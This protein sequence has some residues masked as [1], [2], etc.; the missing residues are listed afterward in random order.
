MRPG[1]AV[2]R[3]KPPARM[4]RP[5]KYEHQLEMDVASALNLPLH[6]LL[7]DYSSG[8]F[9]NLRMAW[10]DAAREYG[11]RRLW[12]HRHYR[13]PMW[14]SILSTAFADGRLPRMTRDDLAAL[15]KPS[16]PGPKREAPQ[17]EKESAS[18]GAVDRQG[19]LHGRASAGKTG[20][21]DHEEI[22]QAGVAGLR[23]P[24]RHQQ[25]RSGRRHHRKAAR[26][27]G[28]ARYGRDRIPGRAHRGIGSR[29]R[30]SRTPT[31]SLPKSANSGSSNPVPSFATPS[32]RSWTAS[33]SPAP[34]RS[35]RNT[36]GLAGHDLPWELIAPR[37]VERAEHRADAVS[38]RA[39]RFAPATARHHRPRVRPVC[40]RH[41]WRR[42]AAGCDRRAELSR[43]HDHRHRKRFSRR[44][45]PRATRPTRASR[46]TSWSRSAC[47]A[48]TCSAAK[49]KRS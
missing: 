40:D 48:P 21:I 6:E 17:P 10:Q 36:V 2:D 20:V 39:V 15:R 11:R 47:S 31:A 8:S 32:T 24:Q 45:Q 27:A 19:H 12:W 3:I 30:R 4:R 34:R 16:W 7:S 37:P 13:L 5:R 44:M 1:E 18:P 38:G 23:N 33:R 9:S 43:H 42:H 41:A 14:A 26:A 22:R 25:A 29:G 49:T 46:R 35:C 28:P